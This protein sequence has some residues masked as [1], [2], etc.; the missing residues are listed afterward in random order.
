MR[1]VVTYIGGALALVLIGSALVSAS[2]FD[3]GSAGLPEF[4]L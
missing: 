2:R 4:F 3:R 1:A